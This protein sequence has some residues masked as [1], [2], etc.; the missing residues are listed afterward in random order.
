MPH[1]ILHPM[2]DQAVMALQLAQLLDDLTAHRCQASTCPLHR[3]DLHPSA[4]T[5][6]AA[7]RSR[8]VAAPGQYVMWWPGTLPAR[9]EN[10]T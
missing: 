6:S 4:D 9:S 8:D 10:H 5:D 1:S 7:A 2:S 3:P